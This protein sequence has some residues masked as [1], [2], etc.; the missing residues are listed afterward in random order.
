M[1]AALLILAVL[2]AVDVSESRS[3]QFKPLAKTAF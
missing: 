2:P 1:F 3:A